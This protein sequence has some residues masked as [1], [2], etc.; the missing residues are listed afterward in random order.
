METADF[1]LAQAGEVYPWNF[2]LVGAVEASIQ[3]STRRNCSTNVVA[4]EWGK[5]LSHQFRLIF[6]EKFQPDCFG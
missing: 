1:C 3:V 6:A 5:L 2:R 4:K